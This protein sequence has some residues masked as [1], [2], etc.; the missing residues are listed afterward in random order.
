MYKLWM[1]AWLEYLIST[2]RHP[3]CIYLC[4]HVCPITIFFE[5][6]VY[7]TGIHINPFL[8]LQWQAGSRLQA[9]PSGFEPDKNSW[10]WNWLERWMAVRPWENRFLDINLRD[11]VMVHENE[12][13]EDMNGTKSHV[14][15]AG[16]KPIAPNLQPNLSSQ[17]TG[18][19]YSDGCGSSPSQSAGMQDA[20]NPLLAKSKPKPHADDP[21]EESNSRPLRSHSN[22][23]ERSTQPDK[24]AKKRLSLPNSGEFSL[25][26]SLSTIKRFCRYPPLSLL[27]CAYPF[28]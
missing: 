24:Q 26:L 3:L 8:F 25:S 10:G 18:P 4:T 14:K 13:A 23:K 16:K 17:K 15:S 20:S 27:V 1:L 2:Q 22:P 19:S 21:V 11:G 28:F 6:L 9:V 7:L 5:I 12:S